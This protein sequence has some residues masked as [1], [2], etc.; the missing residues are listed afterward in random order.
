MAYFCTPTE[1]L[2]MSTADKPEG[3]WSPLLEVRHVEKWENPCSFWDDDGKAYLGRNLHGAYPIVIHRMSEDGIKLLDDGLI[4]YTGPVAEDVKMLKK[5]ATITS[6]FPKVAYYL[7]GRPF[8]TR[9]IS[10]A[11][12]RKRSYCRLLG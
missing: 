5:T 7:D 10:M 1:G 12:T 3:L 8:C 6:V 11:P 9:K 4:V 2:F